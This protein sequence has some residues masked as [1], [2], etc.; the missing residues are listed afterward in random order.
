VTGQ[1][2]LNLLGMLRLRSGP[3]DMPS[4][5]PL[6]IAMSFAYIAQGFFADRILGDTDGASRTLLAVGVQF[7]VIAIL[8]NVRNF[9]SRLPQ[10]LIALAGTGFIFGL[11]SLAI[12]T[13]VD[14]TR[15]Q[16]DLAL[17]YLGL[18]GWSLV[19]DAHIYRQALSFKMGIGVLLAV[20]IFGANFVLL[21][22]VFG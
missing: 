16:P 12:L 10:T 20:L 14:P 18:F 8:L 5:W 9:S 6:A 1:M 15:S 13:R 17:I 19:V 21:K 11:L 3:Q 22:A 4:G 7:M 2:I